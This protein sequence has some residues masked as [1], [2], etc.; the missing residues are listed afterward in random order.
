MRSDRCNRRFDDTK[1]PSQQNQGK[2]DE[3]KGTIKRHFKVSAYGETQHAKIARFVVDLTSG[4]YFRR[5]YL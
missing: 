1:E 2:F 5:D 3:A 4:W